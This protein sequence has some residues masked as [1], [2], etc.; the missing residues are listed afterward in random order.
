MFDPFPCPCSQLGLIPTKNTYKNKIGQAHRPTYALRPY[1]WF[2]HAPSL[3]KE[4]YHASQT[5]VFFYQIAFFLFYQII[6]G[7][8]HVFHP[9][10]FQ[11][12]A[13]HTMQCQLMQMTRHLGLLMAWSGSVEFDD[14]RVTGKSRQWTFN[15]KKLFFNPLLIKK[16]T[17]KK[18][19]RN[20]NKLFMPSN[21]LKT[22]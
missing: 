1:K 4:A 13:T 19:S 11:K 12:N 14:W 17:P 15:Q 7:K 6:E 16:K 10:C 2:A 9:Y 5:F 20:L 8:Q 3:C 21:I 22:M 18:P